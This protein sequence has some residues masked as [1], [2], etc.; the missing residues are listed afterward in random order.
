MT[1]RLQDSHWWF[2]GRRAT[3][4]ALMRRYDSPAGAILDVGCGT[5]ANLAWLS[6][7]GEA[8]GLDPAEEA[9]SA[10]RA[11]GLAADYGSLP[12][13]K[14]PPGSVDTVT[15]FDVLEHVE[16]DAA[17]IRA[18]S[19]A[20][21]PGGKLVMSVPA[22]GWLWSGHDV[23]HHHK[24]RYRAGELR[25]KLASAGLVPLRVSYANMLLS[26]PIVA[27]RILE[28]ASRRG[29]QAES[30]LAPVAEPLNGLLA[31]I[32]SLEAAVVPRLAL[33]FGISI[34]AVAEKPTRY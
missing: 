2:R 20:L 27:A 17:M 6:A 25:A 10:C 32:F 7:F 15:L 34:V 31:R 13:P 9:V 19:D 33:P 14:V 16:D 1:E 22:W 24:R 23:T 5:G 21:R 28:R 26:P 3:L 29:G 4:E 8:R 30:G 18:I 11:K 12:D